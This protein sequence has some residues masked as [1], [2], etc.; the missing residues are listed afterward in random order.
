MGYKI[1]FTL[2]EAKTYSH[3]EAVA[4]KR[5]QVGQ[6][7]QYWWSWRETIDGRWAVNC[8]TGTEPEP[9]WKPMEIT[10]ENQ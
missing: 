6:T 8:D 2:L 5:G 3:N 9:E 4:R 10:N 1:Y 7:I